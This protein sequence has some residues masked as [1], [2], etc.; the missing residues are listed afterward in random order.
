MGGCRGLQPRRDSGARRM[1]LDSELKCAALQAAVV[2]LKR[3][4]GVP[5]FDSVQE[6]AKEYYFFLRDD[7]KW[8]TSE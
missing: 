2:T 5:S 7:T 3:D 8:R 6:L 4:P 1:T